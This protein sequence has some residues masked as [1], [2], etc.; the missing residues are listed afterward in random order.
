VRS[1]IYSL[2][3]VLFHALTGRP[4]FL[5]SYLEVI[6]HHVTTPAPD[7]RTVVPDLSRETADIVA[8]MLEKDPEARP[9]GMGEVVRALS[10]VPPPER[11]GSESPGEVPG[12]LRTRRRDS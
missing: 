12:R 9:T 7:L 6:D 10:R 5:G 3:A 4:P 2:G 8:A 11:E 1:D